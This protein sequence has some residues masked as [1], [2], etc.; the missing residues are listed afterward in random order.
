VFP[1]AAIRTYTPGTTRNLI[2]RTGGK[3]I[4]EKKVNGGMNDKNAE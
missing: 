2:V 4:Y 1:S 3:V